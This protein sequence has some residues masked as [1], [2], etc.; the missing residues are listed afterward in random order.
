MTSRNDHLQCIVVHG[1]VIAI[2]GSY[3]KFSNN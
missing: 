3:S 1:V 2:I